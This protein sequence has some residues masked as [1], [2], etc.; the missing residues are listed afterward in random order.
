MLGNYQ[1]SGVFWI[2][3]PFYGYFSAS[4][5]IPVTKAK[6]NTLPTRKETE[7]IANPSI[8]DTEVDKLRRKAFR[9]YQL[10]NNFCKSV[11]FAKVN[12][13]SGVSSSLTFYQNLS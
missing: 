1:F 7:C 12:G 6:W 2:D 5:K 9:F 8:F 13:S 4:L 10:M 11:V 3:F